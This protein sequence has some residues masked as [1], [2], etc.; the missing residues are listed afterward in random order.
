MRLVWI[1]D[2][3]YLIFMETIECMYCCPHSTVEEQLMSEVGFSR[4]RKVML[5]LCIGRHEWCR[6]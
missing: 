5:H 6:T 2:A 4:G 3:A 1:L